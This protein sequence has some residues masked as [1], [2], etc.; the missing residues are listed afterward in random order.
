MKN[1]LSYK[2]LQGPSPKLQRNIKLQAPISPQRVVRDWS[3]GLGASLELGT[4]SLELCNHVTLQLCNYAVGAPSRRNSIVS[5][6]FC[7]ADVTMTSTLVAAD[8]N[9]NCSWA[10][11]RVK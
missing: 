4:W 1:R 10:S 2:K 6:P 8:S 7:L 9:S 11:L 5:K 3:L